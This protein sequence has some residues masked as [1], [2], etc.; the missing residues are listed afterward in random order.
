MRNQGGGRA[1]KWGRRLAAW[2]LSVALLGVLLVWGV[3]Q[4]GN[5]EVSAPTLAEKQHSY[6]QAINWLRAH[7]SEVL[8]DPNA[9]LWWMLQYTVQRTGDA[10]LASLLNQQDARNYQE[11]GVQRVWRRM[12]YPDSPIPAQELDTDDLS[13]YQQFFHD[14]LICRRDDPRNVA[15]FTANLCRPIGLHILRGDPTCVTHQLM[16]VRLF[17]QS[18]C[19]QAQN[20][21]PL[22][23]ELVSDIKKQLRYDIVFKDVYIQRVLMLT[24]TEGPQA[25]EPAWLRR[26]LAQQQ[27]SGGWLEQPVYPWL[28][29]ALQPWRVKLRL[30]SMWPRFFQAPNPQPTFHATAQGLLLMALSMPAGQLAAPTPAPVG[31]QP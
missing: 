19:P 12:I 5:R 3:L 1:V 4:W 29:E 8:A 23:S 28:P 25:V 20:L 6:Q 16:G 7:E 13:P 18:R 30:N 27:P 24:W 17:M 14:A 31:A 10:Y 2:V 22:Q 9:A 11:L 21:L 15:F 26:V